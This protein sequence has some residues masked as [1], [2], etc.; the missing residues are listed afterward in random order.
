MR[1]VRGGRR[2]NDLGIAGHLDAC[3]SFGV[4]LVIVMRR[5][6]MSSSGR[7]GD[8]GMRVDAAVAPAELRAGLREDR[9]VAFAGLERRLIGGGP[10]RAAVDV[11]E[12]DRTFPSNRGW[13]PR[14]SG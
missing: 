4:R 3:A 13:D 5:S 2:E 1:G 11:A 12:V 10:E 6:S 8:L 7:N 9:L 14:A